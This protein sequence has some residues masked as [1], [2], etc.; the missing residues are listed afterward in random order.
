MQKK[1][2]QGRLPWVVVLLSIVLG[3]V[4]TRFHTIVTGPIALVALADDRTSKPSQI[5]EPFPLTITASRPSLPEPFS[6]TINAKRPSLP[7]PFSMTVTAVRKK[8]PEPF[9]IEL[10]AVR[11]SL[12][13]PFAL[14]IVVQRE[15]QP[16]SRFVGSWRWS[17]LCPTGKYK[18]KYKGHWVI[19]KHDANGN[20]S[21][22]FGNGHRGEFSGRISGTT[23]QFIRS[24][25]RGTKIR[26]NWTGTFWREKAGSQSKITVTGTLSDPE[27]SCGFGA[28]KP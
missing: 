4:P 17:A 28:E 14:N 10:K 27:G 18:G 24:F 1:H 6:M 13:E 20:I 11:P 5:P 25:G 21:G 22:H 12:Q 7:E 3:F 23:I 15:R 9:A 8:L 16:V 2:T 19:S 26:Q